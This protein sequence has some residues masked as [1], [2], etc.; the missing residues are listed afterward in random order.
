MSAAL[1]KGGVTI[2]FDYFQNE[3]MELL[4]LP[5]LFGRSVNSALEA[6]GVSDALDA[7]HA[8]FSGLD[9]NR[10]RLFLSKLLQGACVEVD[11]KGT[12]AAASSTGF[13]T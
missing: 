8:D 13:L 12:E 1:T 10:H 4:V 6:T 3:S 5:Y 11:E 9:G 7:A 2:E